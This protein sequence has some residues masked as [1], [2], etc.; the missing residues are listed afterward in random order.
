MRV[1]AAPVTR[2]IRVSQ[3]RNDITVRPV[4]RNI[5]VNSVG[6]RGPIGGNGIVNHG[7]DADYDRPIS[8]DPIIWIGSVEPLNAL[9]YDLWVS[10]I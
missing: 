3:G 7:A 2:V 8:A 9:D 4:T 5:A 6:R 10:V 1:E